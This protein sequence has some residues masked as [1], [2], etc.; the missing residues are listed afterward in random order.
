MAKIGKNIRKNPEHFEAKRKLLHKERETE[1]GKK[2][3][4]SLEYFET[5]KQIT[6]QKTVL[7]LIK[8]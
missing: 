8:Q 4:K 2:I 1:I 7:N 5:K 6:T 3:R